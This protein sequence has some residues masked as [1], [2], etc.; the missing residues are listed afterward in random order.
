M[1][2]VGFPFRSVVSLKTARMKRPTVQELRSAGTYA[3]L[4]HSRTAEWPPFSLYTEPQCPLMK[5]YDYMHYAAKNSA[6]SFRLSE[7]MNP[8]HAYGNTTEPPLAFPL[9]VVPIVSGGPA[10]GACPRCFNC[11]KRHGAV[12]PVDALR[13]R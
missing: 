13:I 10:P 5:R 1:A 8:I 3:L 12:V 6:H 2:G 7:R 9:D 11:R 4:T